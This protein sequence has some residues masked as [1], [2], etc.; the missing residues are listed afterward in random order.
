MYTDSAL[1]NADAD[2]DEEG[3]DDECLAKAKQKMPAPSTVRWSVWWL[4][5]PSE[6]SLIVRACLIV[7]PEDRGTAFDGSLS[8]RE[9]FGRSGKRPTK[10]GYACGYQHE[11]SWQTD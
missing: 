1:H 9:A 2:L 11:Y 4:T 6:R 8:A 3:S 10:Y 7:S 5:C